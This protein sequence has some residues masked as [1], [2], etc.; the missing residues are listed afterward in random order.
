MNDKTEKAPIA[1]FNDTSFEIQNGKAS[2]TIDSA[3]DRI[4]IY[5]SLDITATKDGLTKAKEL[6]DYL[7]HVVKHLELLEYM[8]KLPDVEVIE[9]PVMKDNPFLNQH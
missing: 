8:G 7:N 1:P 4:A 6:T 3:E 5:G 2:L 9:A